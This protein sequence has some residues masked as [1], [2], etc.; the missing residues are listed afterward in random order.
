[1]INMILLLFV[2][3]AD[4]ISCQI[5]SDER[6]ECLKAAISHMLPKLHVCIH[7]TWEIERSKVDRQMYQSMFLLF[8]F[9]TTQSGLQALNIP[10]LDP[11][12]YN[13]TVINFR[14]GEI[15]QATGNVKTASIYGLTR[16]QIKNLKYVYISHGSL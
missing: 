8:F 7:R 4:L 9:R 12:S 3:V 1:M 10:P 5:D 13:N 15:L 6:D 11:L 14:R 2:A 16:A